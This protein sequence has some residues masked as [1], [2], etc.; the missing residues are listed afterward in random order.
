M[1]AGIADGHLDLVVGIAAVEPDVVV[2][3]VAAEPLVVAGVATDHLDMVVDIAA[4]EPGHVGGMAFERQPVKTCR[5][6]SGS[7]MLNRGAFS[8]ILSGVMQMTWNFGSRTC[9]SLAQRPGLYHPGILWF[10]L[11][12]YIHPSRSVLVHRNF[13]LTYSIFSVH[14]WQPSLLKFHSSR[15]NSS[16]YC[17]IHASATSHSLYL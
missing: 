16:V 13:L 3:V 6:T 12:I 7:T 15:T 4:V 2:H 5:S 17:C 1:V 9:S 10:C 14:Y 11:C 8:K